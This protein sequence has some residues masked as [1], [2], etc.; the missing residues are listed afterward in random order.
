MRSSHHLLGALALALGTITLGGCTDHRTV[1]DCNFEIPPGT[2]EPGEP[3]TNDMECVEDSICF[4]GTCVGDGRLRVSLAWE[5]V[6][7]FD[8]HVITPS[9]Y[10]IYYAQPTH[11]TG[12]LDVDDCIVQCRDN[13]GTHVE[14]VFFGEN[15]QRGEY[16]VFVENFNG[17]R[18]GEFLLEV[19]GEGVRDMWDGTLPAVANATSETFTFVYDP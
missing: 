8:L 2:Q 15:A 10:E 12:E 16:R 5:V 6:S 7:D 13:S 3:C 18:A 11:N 9:G 19:S 17:R 1:T 14:N 4:S